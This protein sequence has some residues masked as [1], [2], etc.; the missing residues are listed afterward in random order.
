MKVKGKIIALVV[1]PLFLPLMI[2]DVLKHIFYNISL[3]TE[4]IGDWFGKIDFY[5]ADKSKKFFK[6]LKNQ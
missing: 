4:A 3:F 1:L 2:P 5:L 6:W